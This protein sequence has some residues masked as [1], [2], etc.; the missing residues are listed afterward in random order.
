MRPRNASFIAGI[1]AVICV[2]VYFSPKTFT[3]SSTSM[4]PTLGMSEYMFV[5]PGPIA[6]G[7]KRGDVVVFKYP[8]Q[9][10]MKFVKRVIGLPG[11]VIEWKSG[12]VIN[13]TPAVRKVLEGPIPEIPDTEG[14]NPAGTRL[15]EESFEGL[16][17]VVLDQE[18]P[19]EFNGPVTVPPDHYY[20]VG[21]FRTNSHDS[22]RWGFLPK[23]NLL[24]KV[25]R[26][27]WSS[28]LN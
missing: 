26:M 22:R 27:P 2:A 18:K 25:A 10:D 28:G 19:D 12:L 5:L 9:P 3:N 8:V 14:G 21:D 4:M 16:T 6:L 24:G 17:F 15:I 23:Q 13:G 7:A 11:D 1:V 20:V